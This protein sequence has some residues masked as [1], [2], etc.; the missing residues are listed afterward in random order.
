MS[1]LKITAPGLHTTVQDLGRFGYQDVGMPVAG[2]LDAESLRLANGLLGNPPG[3]AALE[4][5]FQGPTIEVLAES[6]RVALVGGDA[7][8][9]I[10]GEEKL[11]V[12]AGQTVRLVE[13]QS[14]RIGAIADAACCYLAVEG[15]FA[16][17]PV[18][19]SLSTYVRGRIGG[20]E[21]RALKANDILPLAKASAEERE[22]QR[23]RTLPAV[24]KDRTIRV[25][26]GPQDDYFTEESLATFLAADYAVSKSADRMGLRLDGPLL[27]HRETYNIASDGIA[28]GAIQVPGSGQP[29][30]L[31]ADHQT[32]GG[33]PKIAT[34]ISADLPLVARRRTSDKIRFAAVSVAEAEA[35][36][37]AFEAA[38][39]EQLADLEPVRP[40][41]R[42]D[43]KRLYSHNLIS[44]VVSAA[45]TGL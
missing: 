3:T 36:R 32:A 2:A 26:L 8:L 5:I 39:Q 4:I 17:T 23:L 12:P 30:L 41:A 20:V 35:A 34:V 15:G 16:L 44:G 7:A 33:Y 1:G 28:T 38:L 11:L 25:V 31:L 24:G 22:E 37:R 10:L 14:F 9:E 40:S 21:G 29:I 43:L 13:G 27:R 45:E 19:G 42:I 18:L 6:A